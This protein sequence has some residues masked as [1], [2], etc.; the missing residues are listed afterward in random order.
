MLEIQLPQVDK[1]AIGIGLQADYKV[2]SIIFYVHVN[3]FS[4]PKV[5]QNGTPHPAGSPHETAPPHSTQNTKS[6]LQQV[7]I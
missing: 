2:P 6:V 4:E 3:P 1:A 7:Q 5:G